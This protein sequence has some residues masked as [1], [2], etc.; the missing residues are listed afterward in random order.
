MKGL[1]D[2]P[3]RIAPKAFRPGTY[4]RCSSCGRLLR[5]E[6]ATHSIVCSCGAR[7]GP[8]PTQQEKKKAGPA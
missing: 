3:I 7:I 1:F 6:W 4:L 8:D 2:V 5:I